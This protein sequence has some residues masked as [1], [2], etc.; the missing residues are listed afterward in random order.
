MRG[1]V[2][3][4]DGWQVITPYRTFPLKAAYGLYLMEACKRADEQ[5]EGEGKYV[6]HHHP[7]LEEFK[8]IRKKL[9]SPVWW[10]EM[11]LKSWERV[12]G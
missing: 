6:P 2:M 4:E 9:R 8:I 10:E 12:R 3:V 1:R 11:K 5:S 7:T